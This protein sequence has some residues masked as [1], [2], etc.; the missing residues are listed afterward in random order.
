MER[1]FVVVSVVGKR[2]S[3]TKRESEKER[4]SKTFHVLYTFNL[5]GMNSIICCDKYQTEGTKRKQ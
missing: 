5:N 3:F 4:E 2:K 1:L